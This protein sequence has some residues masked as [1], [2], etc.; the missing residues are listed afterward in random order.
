MNGSKV[1]GFVSEKDEKTLGR[2]DVKFVTLNIFPRPL[3]EREE[4]LNERSEFR[5]SGEGSDK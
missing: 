4:F 1:E 2:K 5:N 3:W